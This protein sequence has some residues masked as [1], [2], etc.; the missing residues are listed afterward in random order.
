VYVGLCDV[1]ETT[2]EDRNAEEELR[3]ESE[4]LAAT[5]YGESFLLESPLSSQSK[6]PRHLLD[7]RLR[8]ATPHLF[9][10]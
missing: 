10:S 8:T 9:T 5:Y 2:N 4:E 1:S 7:V 3:S 6:E